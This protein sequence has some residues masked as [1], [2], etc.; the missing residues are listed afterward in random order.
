MSYPD[1]RTAPGFGE[2]SQQPFENIPTD[3]E[4][5]LRW[6]TTLAPDHPFKYELSN[7]K[8]SRMMINVTR[9]HWE[10]TANILAELLPKLDRSRFRAGPTE[11]GVRTGVGVRYPDVVVDRASPRRESLACEAPIFIAEVLS[12]STA[13]LDFTVKLHEYQ[14]IASVQTYLICSQDEPRAWVWQRGIDGR[15]PALPIELTGREGTIALGG[16]GIELSTVAIFLGIPDAPA[17]E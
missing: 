9:G 6:G 16:L 2:R 4:A 14:A 5:F 15:W 7:G 1:Y 8:V 17:R 3:T 13:G 10:V 11:F 12:P